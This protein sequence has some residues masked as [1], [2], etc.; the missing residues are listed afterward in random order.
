MFIQFTVFFLPL[1]CRQT[2][3]FRLLWCLKFC[4]RVHKSPLLDFIQ[5]LNQLNR[6]HALHTCF[7]STLLSK[8]ILI[9]S[10]CAFLV[11]YTFDTWPSKTQPSDVFYPNNIWWIVQLRSSLSWNFIVVCHVSS[12]RFKCFP[13]HSFSDKERLKKNVTTPCTI[14]TAPC[15]L[16]FTAQFSRYYWV[17]LL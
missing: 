17:V 15:F 11:S 3:D 12:F 14:H 8:G 2:R 10:L 16:E 5:Q 4:Y 13:L 9:K 6:V 7:L 1:S